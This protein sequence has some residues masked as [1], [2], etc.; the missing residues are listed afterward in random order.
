MIFGGFSERE[1]ERFSVC[2]SEFEAGATFL[3]RKEKGG[4]S[5]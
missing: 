5:V 4:L 2:F 1:R 3:E